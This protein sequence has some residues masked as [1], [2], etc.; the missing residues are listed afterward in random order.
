[1]HF[2][3]EQHLA[4]AKLLRMKSMDR[5]GVDRKRLI[6]MSNSFVIGARLAAKDRGGICLDSFDWSS[7]FPDWNVIETWIRQLTPFNVQSPP[8]VPDFLTTA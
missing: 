2:S 5:I 1:M 4:A 7:Q 6:K 8:L 3:A